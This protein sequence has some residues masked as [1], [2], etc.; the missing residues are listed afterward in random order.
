MGEFNILV[1]IQFIRVGDQRDHDVR[2]L[3]K[4]IETSY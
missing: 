4:S 2:W 1:E 3:G